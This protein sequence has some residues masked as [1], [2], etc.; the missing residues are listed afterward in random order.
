MRGTGTVTGVFQ[1]CL[2]CVLGGRQQV[3]SV[4]ESVAILD[5]KYSVLFQSSAE[6]QSVDR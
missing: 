2:E 1:F 3:A 5:V 6:A 4:V